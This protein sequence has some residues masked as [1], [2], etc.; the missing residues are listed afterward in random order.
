MELYALY[1][2]GSCGDNNSCKPGTF[3]MRGKKK[4]KAW[5]GKKGLI[6]YRKVCNIFFF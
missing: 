3:D 2:Q 6:I 4:W 5:N 1:K